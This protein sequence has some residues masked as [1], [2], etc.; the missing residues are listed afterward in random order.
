MSDLLGLMESTIAELKIKH[1]AEI[2]ALVEGAMGRNYC[3]AGAAQ[4]LG[5]TPIWLSRYLHKN[6]ELVRASEKIPS[7][8]KYRIVNLT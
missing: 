8:R 2:W 3:Q 4:D 5:V 6:R 7:Y 1:D